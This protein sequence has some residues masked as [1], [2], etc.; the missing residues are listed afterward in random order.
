MTWCPALGGET[1]EECIDSI[2]NGV[3]S[4]LPSQHWMYYIYVLHQQKV[5]FWGAK[6]DVYKH[7]K[8]VGGA[9]VSSIAVRYK[10]GLHYAL[11]T[12]NDSWLFT[13]APY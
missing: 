13:D 6:P 12:W 1:V 3:G 4:T 7:V 2:Q 11:T 8:A 9:L 10:E 5:P